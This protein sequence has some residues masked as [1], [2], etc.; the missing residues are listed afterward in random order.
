MNFLQPVD[1]R[2]LMNTLKRLGITP[3]LARD[4][5][6]EF[7]RSYICPPYELANVCLEEMSQLFPLPRLVT[8]WIV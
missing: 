5:Y 6:S 7:P 4:H 1:G 2:P 3:S 8:P